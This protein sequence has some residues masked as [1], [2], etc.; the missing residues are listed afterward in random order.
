MSPRPRPPGTSLIADLDCSPWEPAVLMSSWTVRRSS[1]RSGGGG[2]LWQD[3]K[4]LGR[5]CVE[6]LAGV[7]GEHVVWASPLELQQGHD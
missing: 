4:R 3:A 6:R 5:S 2:V 1:S 7:E